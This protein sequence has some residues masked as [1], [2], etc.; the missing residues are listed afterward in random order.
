MSNMINF[1]VIFYSRGKG[2]D[3]FS[4]DKIRAANV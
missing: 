1:H 2:S 4:L 3:P